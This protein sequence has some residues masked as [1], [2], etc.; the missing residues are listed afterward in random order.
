MRNVKLTKKD[1]FL[2]KKKLSKLRKNSWY[3]QAYKIILAN[4]KKAVVHGRHCVDTEKSL[5]T[6]KIGRYI[7]TTLLD[8][9]K[10][11]SVYISFC[12]VTQGF[13]V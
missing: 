1:M 13:L 2:S 11:S 12:V 10:S 4:R 9:L 3:I 8:W 5:C 7:H 6:Q